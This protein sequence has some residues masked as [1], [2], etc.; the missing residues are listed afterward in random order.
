ML[1]ITKVHSSRV[2]SE[3]IYE[4]S[5]SCYT[6]SRRLGPTVLAASC[7]PHFEHCSNTLGSQARPVMEEI[8]RDPW[9]TLSRI[10]RREREWR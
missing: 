4:I 9:L 8:L 2:R 3:G 5:M 6:N 1:E 7:Q 10:G